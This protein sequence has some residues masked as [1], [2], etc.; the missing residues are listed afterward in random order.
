MNKTLN[1]TILVVDDSGFIRST[2]Q[3]ALEGE[4]LTVFTASDGKK[5]LDF[6]ISSETPEIDIILTDLN[7]PVMDGAELCIEIRKRIELKSKPVIFLTSQS[8]SETE[9]KLFQIGATDFLVKPF[10]KELLVARILVH[11]ESQMSKRYLEGEI[12][13]Q[14]VHLRHA[15]EDAEAAN[16]AKSEFLA[17]MSHEIRTPMNG[18]IGMADLILDTNLDS[19]QQDFAYSIKQSAESLLTIINDILDFSKIEAGKLE[20]ESIDLD[21]RKTV[22]DIGQLMATK[23]QEKG[24]E[25]ICLIQNDVPNFLKGDPGRLRQILINL[26]GNSVKFVEK[27]EVLIRISLD[28]ETNTH[29]F[30]KFEVIDTGIG[31]SKSQQNKLFK[32]FSQADASTTRKYGGTGLGL[33]I[34]KQLSKLM[35][36]E[37]GVE[38]EQ[39]KGSIFWFTA[40]LEKLPDNPKQSQNKQILRRL[41]GLNCLI[42]DENSSSRLSLTQILKSFGCNCKDVSTK[43]DALKALLNAHSDKLPFDTVFIDMRMDK[44]DSDDSLSKKIKSNSLIKYTHLVLMSYATDKLKLS[45]LEKNGFSSQISKPVYDLNILECLNQKY[46]LVTE[47]KDVE[48]RF[49]LEEKNATGSVSTTVLNILLAEDNKMNQKVAINMLKKI[50]HSYKIAENGKKAVEEFKNN[51]YDLILMDGQMPEMDGFEATRQIR[52]IEKN[53]KDSKH[54]PIIA[55][56]ANAMKGDRERFIEAGMDDYLTKP[57]KREA[58]AKAIS[59][60]IETDSKKEVEKDEIIDLNE[61]IQIVNGNKELIKECFDDFVQHYL[62]E[63]VKIEDT[64]KGKDS[65]KSLQLLEGFRDWVKNLASKPIMDAAFCLERAIKA[66]N[67]E[68]IATEFNNLSKRCEKLQDFIIRYSVKNLFM[69]FLIVDDEFVSRKKTAKILSKYGECNMAINGLEALNAVY[70]SYKANTPYSL[71]FLDINMPDIS[72]IKVVENIR[73]WEDSQVISIKDRVKIVML[74]AD[75]SSQTMTSSFMEGCESYIIKPINKEKITKAFKKVGYI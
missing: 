59:A 36:G 14:T 63:L 65:S 73:K 20:L 28:K 1:P 16:I 22:Y 75:D 57:V 44:T 13:K 47:T 30:L 25:F 54:I 39:G 58:L 49:G 7:M 18:V 69:K 46:G 15:K 38:S 56:T 5:A 41:K 29:A 10:I 55:L 11:L 37:I 42:V 17:N 61:V 48:T 66:D 4:N 71:I 45:I 35:N 52:K 53:S 12:N 64:I 2:V 26:S 23:A 51:K 60:F 72:G 21:L 50:G 62:Q 3:K 70:R 27:G 67:S 34:S 24:I 33:T 31:I 43:P 40:R 32:S 74:S 9:N 8:G 6:L 68:K 19:E